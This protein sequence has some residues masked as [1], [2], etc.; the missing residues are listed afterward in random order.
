MSKYSHIARYVMETPWA[1]LPSKL[2]ELEAILQFHMAGGKF[3]D[4]ELRA[5]IGDPTAA[6]QAMVNGA[7]AI[8]PLRGVIA[9]RM[10]GMTEM[11]GAMSTERFS[12]MFRQVLADPAVS[13]IVIDTDS[14]GGSIAGVP[15]LAAEIMAARGRK[16]IIAHA[17]ALM[18]SAA[19]WIC[20]AA[21]EIVATP[22]AMVGSIGVL[23][24]HEDT[25]K[26]DEAEGITRTLI[27]AGKFK[28]EGFGPLT[29]EAKAAIQ[30]RVDEAYAQMTKDIAKGRGVTAAAVRSGFGEGRVV[31]A[32]EAKKLGMVDRIATM[33][34][35]IGRLVGRKAPAGMR[36]E[37]DPDV[38]AAMEQQTED[39]AAAFGVPASLIDSDADRRRRMERF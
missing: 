25:S 7:V 30:A 23:T 28:G 36:A 5:R 2:E 22:S 15:E 34:E 37:V 18:A 26:A 21:D 39:I 19:F 10:G 31:S 4:E 38:L 24:A 6:P 16:P 12:Q 17:N 13:A 33:D 8:L 14:P 3:S 27:T 32:T 1:M 20:A 29:D 11:S 9:H 35:T